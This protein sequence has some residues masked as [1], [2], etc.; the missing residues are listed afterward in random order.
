MHNGLPMPRPIILIAALLALGLIIACGGSE[1]TAVPPA[2]EVAA[3]SPAAAEP[4]ATSPAGQQPAAPSP[5][6]EQ[7]P[8]PTSPAS[9]RLAPTV[10]APASNPTSTP[11]PVVVSDI[12]GFG[13]APHYGGIIPMNTFESPGSDTYYGGNNAD[14]TMS[15][16]GAIFNQIVEFDPDTREGLDLRGG[17][18][19]SWD[20]SQDGLTYTFELRKGMMFHDGTPLEMKD[21]LF[22]LTTTF[23]PDDIEFPEVRDEIQGRT[24]GNA[25]TVQVY[26]KDWEAVD[27]GS[28]AINLNFPSNAFM[29]SLAAHRFP[30]ISK[31]A[32]AEHGTFRVPNEGTLVGTGPFMFVRYDKDIVTEVEKNPNYHLEGQPYIDGVLHFPMFDVGTII[33][34]FKTEQ[35]LISSDFVSNLTIPDVLKL[36]E[37]MGDELRVIFAAAPPYSMG[38]MMNAGKKPFDDPRVRRAMQLIVH[39]QPLIETLSAGYNMIGTPIPCGFAWGFT[40]E[41]ALEMP[42]MRELNG[43]KHPDDIAEAQRLMLEAGAGPGTKLEFTC[44]L[45]IE[46]CDMLPIVKSQLQKWLGWELTTRSLESTAGY[47]RY[48]AGDYDFAIQAVGFSFPDPDASAAS[49]RKNSTSHTQRTFFYN[50][51]AEPLWKIINTE[52]DFDKR[53]DAVLKVN[54]LLLEDSSWALGYHPTIGW[55]V[56]TRIKN[57]IDPVGRA[58][59]I[60]WD[61]IWCDTC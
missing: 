22:T 5:A 50:E 42:G 27:E 40:C 34:A 16:I 25:Q 53:R 9:I 10:A 23:N 28:L 12:P 35:V 19:E 4:A 3:T 46:Y 55:P 48:R 14:N 45:V 51:E 61:Q 8:T 2:A 36:Q 59:Y 18:T 32:V 20:I 7:K 60:Q 17:V 24:L 38:V 6:V 30:V 49:F 11:L 54:Q 15:H 57:F 43:E 56:N 58:A 29:T 21:V 13:E 26:M 37:E 1:A 39:R 44:R 33:A 41:E 31:D 52:T 47:D